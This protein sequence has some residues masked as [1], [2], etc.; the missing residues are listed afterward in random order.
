MNYSLSVSII[1]K[2]TVYFSPPL[3]FSTSVLVFSFTFWFP[4]LFTKVSANPCQSDLVELLLDL[5]ELLL[6]VVP[7]GGAGDVAHGPVAGGTL[8]EGFDELA[9]LGGVAGVCAQVALGE[10]DDEL[11]IV[12]HLGAAVGDGVFLIKVHGEDVS[13]ADVV[14]L[15]LGA[16]SSVGVDKVS[17]LILDSL[18]VT[19]MHM[20]VDN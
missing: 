6:V 2:T 11:A 12:S 19:K 13:R 5:G 16:I 20:L 8:V 3:F 9:A 10:E 18:N 17:H 15:G 7:D 4:N 14:D 1:K